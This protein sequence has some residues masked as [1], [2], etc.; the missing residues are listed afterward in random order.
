AWGRAAQAG[1]AEG[2]PFGAFR[3]GA[4][5]GPA[6][7]TL[8]K[9]SLRVGPTPATFL[10]H[11]GGRGRGAWYGL[12]P[13]QCLRPVAAAKERR[14]FRLPAGPQGR[15]RRLLADKL[16]WAARGVSLSILARGARPTRRIHQIAEWRGGTGSAHWI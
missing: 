12:A 3:G 5:G 6:F 14:A 8:G 4:A 1:A 9:S 13:S 16:P 2:G 10:R 15:R 11:F 7:E